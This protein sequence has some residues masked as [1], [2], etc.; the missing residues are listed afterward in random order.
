MI[1]Y[2]T[3]ILLLIISLLFGFFCIHR[4][5]E[6]ILNRLIPQQIP[7]TKLL[8]AEKK[9]PIEPTATIEDSSVQI[10]QSVERV[11]P[12]V[13]IQV[14]QSKPKKPIVKKMS[15]EELFSD[16]NG[17]IKDKPIV[18]EEIIP[19]TI[20]IEEA[21]PTPTPTPTPTNTTSK[22]VSKPIKIEDKSNKKSE[23]SELERLMLEEMKKIK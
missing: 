18:T 7:E 9:T 1:R 10:I 17:S 12:V 3:L 11:E 8:R 4:H 21:T 20:T 6:S 14:D 13:T 16:A 19:K 23:M 22:P 2:I 15:T 5:E